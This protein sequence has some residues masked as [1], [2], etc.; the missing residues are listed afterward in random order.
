M[1]LFRFLDDYF[2]E[3]LVIIL[4]AGMSIIIGIQV[5]MRYV[6]KSSLSWSEELA[7]YMFIWMIYIGISY[8]VKKDKHVKIEAVLT[9]LSSFW[10]K[11]LIII[12]DLLFLFFAVIIVI[13][14]FEVSNTI[15]NLGQLS[16]GMELP[17]WIVYM[18]V[19]VEFSLVCIRLIQSLIRK[20]RNFSEK[21]DSVT[22]AE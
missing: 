18:A 15:Q 14:S 9:V 8:G 7:R 1:K 6:L 21:T 17:M 20:I 2:E 5:F 11:V 22:A 19:P 16:P 13:K 12:S 10:K 4:L 3:I